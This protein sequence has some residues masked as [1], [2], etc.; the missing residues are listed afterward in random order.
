MWVFK[1]ENAWRSL[2]QGAD[3]RIPAI[4]KFIMTF[5]TPLYLGVILVTWLVR[6]AIPILTLETTPV[7]GTVPPGSEIYVHLSRLLIVAFIVFFLVMIRIAWKRN[8][9]DDRVGFVEVEDTPAGITPGHRSEV[10]S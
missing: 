6:D 9:Y 2:H 3:I 10:V 1:P 7:G 5:V 4:F 8:K